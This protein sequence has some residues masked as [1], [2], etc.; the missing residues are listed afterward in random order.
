MN[1]IKNNTM[2]TFY[3]SKE[4]SVI[5]Y[6][7]IIDTMVIKLRRNLRNDLKG[8]ADIDWKKTNNKANI[9]VTNS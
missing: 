2:I 8:I 9:N 5:N 1:A 3:T 7:K 6:S 4:S